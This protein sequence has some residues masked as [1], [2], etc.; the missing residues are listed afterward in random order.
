MEHARDAGEALSAAKAQLDHGQWLPWLEENCPTVSSRVAQMYMRIARSW[1]ELQAAANTKRVSHLPLREALALLA[2]PTDDQALPTTT[3]DHAIPLGPGGRAAD[4]ASITEQTD[5]EA[6]AQ[7][8]TPP[9][10]YVRQVQLLF[11]GDGRRRF[12]AQCGV[13]KG[14]YGTHTLTDTVAECVRRAAN[15]VAEDH[16]DPQDGPDDSPPHDQGPDAL[17]IPVSAR[18]SDAEAEQLGGEQLDESSYDVLL[19]GGRA[20]W[21]DGRE[22]EPHQTI[23][24]LKE[25]GS[26]LVTYRH[27]VLVR[28]LCETAYDVFEH[29][30]VGTDNRG[31][32]AGKIMRP[33]IDGRAVG[34][35]T[36]TRLRPVKQDGTLS[37]TTY[38]QWVPS[39]IVGFFDRNQR[40]P[41]CRMTAFNLD[42]EPEFERGRPF[43]Q[44]VDRMFRDSC[45]ERYAA[46]QAVAATT[47]DFTIRGTSFSTI[48]LNRSWST[49]VHQDKGDLREGLGVIAVLHSGEYQGCYLTFPQYRVALDLRTG[50]VALADF[51][52]EWHGNTPI[53]GTPDTYVRL[54]LVFYYRAGMRACG[55][56]EQELQRAKQ[57]G[58]G[59]LSGSQDAG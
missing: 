31:M 26:P 48:T 57:L 17:S 20:V 49:A 7:P 28:D 54:S 53:V 52:R 27:N 36:Q 15:V 3:E 42:H 47:P 35:L 56:A 9:D 39:A 44:A 29:M 32:A 12:L 16:P 25:D 37:R 34:E 24:F 41:Y 6:D 19:T 18:L 21:R 58:V 46:Q 30:K 10:A 22:S 40:F 13:L 33:D 50:D 23:V 59:D 4:D 51:G 45:P 55:S 1:Q 2:D 43:V 5:E 14:V 8:S 38:A 11:D